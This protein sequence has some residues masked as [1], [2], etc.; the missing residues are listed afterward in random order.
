MIRV[1]LIGRALA[2]RQEFPGFGFE[3]CDYTD[4]TR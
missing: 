3:I 4:E 2:A 1:A